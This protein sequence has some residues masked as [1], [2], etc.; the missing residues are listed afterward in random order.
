MIQTVDLFSIILIVSGLTAFE[1]CGIYF[2]LNKK[3]S[4]QF[5]IQGRLIKQYSILGVFFTSIVGILIF[6]AITNVLEIGTNSL[7]A[8]SSQVFGI[9]LTGLIESVRTLQLPTFINLKILL[10]SCLICYILNNTKL[11]PMTIISGIVLPFGTYIVIGIGAVLSYVYHTKKE[12]Q[13]VIFSGLSIGDGLISS[14][15]IMLKTFV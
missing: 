11:S 4:Q 15:F 13:G 9:T 1:M 12:D 5:N 10:I 2:I 3:V 8:P 6:I 7:P 14:I